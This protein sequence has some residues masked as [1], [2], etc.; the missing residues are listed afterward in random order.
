M[1]RN[2]LLAL[3]AIVREGS[4]GR[5]ARALN[6]SQAAVSARIGALEREVGG[7]LFTRGGRRATL[8][9]TGEAFLPHARRALAVLA[10]GLATA[11]EVRGG[12]AGR[13]TL[14]APDS[15]VEGFLAPGIARYLAAHP[16]VSLAVTI[17]HTEQIVAALRHD[18]AV[19]GIVTWPFAATATDLVPLLRFREPLLAVV[20]VAHPL[21]R[22]EGVTLAEFIAGAAPFYPIA[23]GSTHGQLLE[24][25]ARVGDPAIELPHELVRR[26]IATGRGGAF[27]PSTIIANARPGDDLAVVPLANNESPLRELALVRHADRPDL[28][29]AALALIAAIAGA[30]SEIIVRP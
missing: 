9:T 2:Q 13:V 5:A 26:L 1:D 27:F 7:P 15:T 17:G 18:L 3:D 21:A 8:T 4:F 29:P 25:P 19:L 16:R 30:A 10:E 6:L 22:A 12:H 28:A 23:W 20:G 11:Q 24:R 14:H